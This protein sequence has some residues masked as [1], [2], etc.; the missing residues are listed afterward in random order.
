MIGCPSLRDI[1]SQIRRETTSVG[2]PA[3]KGTMTV[4]GLVGYCAT[5]G[6]FSAARTNIP[7]W[8]RATKGILT[9][10]RRCGSHEPS[11]AAVFH[12]L[13]CAVRVSGGTEDSADVSLRLD[14]SGPDHLAPLFDLG[15]D[16]LPKSAGEPVS[17]VPP[18]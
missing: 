9:S 1:C 15:G 7:M 16:E 6:V 17:T 2:P 4:M 13:V 12:H 11:C 10:L 3:A 8:R 14:V 18:R 5:A